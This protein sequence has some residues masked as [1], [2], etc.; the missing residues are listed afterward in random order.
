M[1]YKDYGKTGKKISVI[2]YGGM[3]FVKDGD[4]YDVDK[5]ADVVRKAN[6]LGVNYFDTAPYYC[7]DMS[8]NIMGRAFQKMPEQ[9]YVSTKSGEKDGDR[10]RLQ[11]EKSLK[12][13]GLSKID[14]FHIWCV[15][16]MDD[17]R[18]RMVK[19]GAYDAAL[20]A[21]NE[22]LVGHIAISTHCSGEE[23]ETIVKEGAFEGVTL[24]YNILNAPY[25]Q[26]GLKAAYLHGM[27][28]ATMNPLGGGLIPRKAEYFDFIKGEEDESVVEAALRFNGSHKE[29]TT[30]LAGMGSIDE[31]LENVKV[32]NKTGE[33]PESRLKEIES[34][35]TAA[36]D[37]LCT[38]CAY[39]RGCPQ[40]IDI[41]KL[42]LAYNE[43]TLGTVKDG[44]NWLRWHWGMTKETAGNCT[45]CGVCESKCTQH[46]PI[47][48]RLKEMVKW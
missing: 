33:F 13:M 31:V 44:M 6:E 35:L 47:A 43:K 36:M 24:G 26:K 28:V 30:V 25:R 42:M 21:K 5:C 20:K 32:G 39:C 46:L 4:K 18:S 9:F 3:R 22:G 7:D 8:E 19:G 16:T 2:G 48:K 38:G 29:I 11:L 14:F 10:L 1:L 17:Y 27:G 37:R 40:G 34:R 45:Q 23:I 15:Q 12:R 41:P